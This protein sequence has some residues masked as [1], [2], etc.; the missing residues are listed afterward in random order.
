MH[1]TG[2]PGEVLLIFPIRKAL[3]SRLIRS[4]PAQM[5]VRLT[6]PDYLVL[7][8]IQEGGFRTE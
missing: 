1:R 8:P 6:V 7:P 5:T 3:V 4:E 2:V